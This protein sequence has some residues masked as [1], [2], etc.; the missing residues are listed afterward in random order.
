MER[1]TAR[2]LRGIAA[3]LVFATAAFHLWWGFRRSVIYLMA[4]DRWLATG[5]PPDPRPFFFVAFAAIL[6]AG[7]YFVTRGLV[8]LRNAYVVGTVLLCG[9][10]AAWVFWH[11]TGHG[12]FL[13][14]GFSA[15]GGGGG[16]HH[17]GDTNAVVL[18]LSHYVTEPVESAIKT[19]ELAGVAIFV[20]LLWRDP[21]I[22]PK[23]RDT[24]AE[25][26]DV[27]KN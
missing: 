4:A 2:I 5:M 16:G 7:P 20:T 23:D 18:V 3:A 9:S 6:L 21:A 15:P 24:G 19:I 26:G 22:V 11:T 10:I 12:A 27:S 25:A 13:V 8:S 1:R 17:S 14:D